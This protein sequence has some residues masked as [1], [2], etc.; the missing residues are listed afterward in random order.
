MIELVNEMLQRRNLETK[1]MKELSNII[2]TLE[3]SLDDKKDSNNIMMLFQQV[4][5]KYG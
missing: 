4:I 5:N 3:A 2:D 1:E